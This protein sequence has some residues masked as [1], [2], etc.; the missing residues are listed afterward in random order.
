MFAASSNQR[1]V[2]VTGGGTFLGNTIASAL[3]GE[4]A[5]VTLLVRPGAEE[6]IGVLADHVRWAV[7]DVWDVAALRGRARNHGCVINTVGSLIADP[8]QGLS[9]HRLNF[10]SARNVINMCVSDGV[11]H[12]ILLSSARAPWLDGQ[13]LHAKREAEHYV[14]RVGMNASI[15]RAPLVYE[16]GR[17]RPLFFEF[18]SL[19]GR[20][21][22]FA[23]LGFARIAPI[24][25][26]V[27]A[28]AVA[29]IAL[30]P[31]RD[32]TIYYAA[33]LRRKNTRDELRLGRISLPDQPVIPQ[34]KS[35]L[36][37]DEAPFGWTP[38]R[39]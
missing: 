31:R 35:P 34:V 20:L 33:D 26:D 22:P 25:V 4:G 29:R 14:Q 36:L 11:P 21:P 7:A 10:V 8:V 1:R 13:Y 30:E 37:E 24:P 9:H 17:S 2:L 39:V 27:L 16:R 15:I 32:K 23:W 19:F 18:M 38:P 6:R 12:V 5:E 28:R 3:L